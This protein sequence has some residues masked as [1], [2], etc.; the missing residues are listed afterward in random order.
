MLVRAGVFLFCVIRGGRAVVVFFRVESGKI[1]TL[2]AGRFG[3]HKISKNPI[4]FFEIT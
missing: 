3:N 1:V 4:Q 2:I